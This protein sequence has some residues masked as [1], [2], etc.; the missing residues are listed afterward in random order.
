MAALAAEVVET[1]RLRLQ[2]GDVVVAHKVVSVAEGR[3]VPLAEVQPS[4]EAVRLAREVGKDPRL[5]GLV[6][7]E[8]WEV[9]RVLQR[10]FGVTDE[11]A[12]AATLPNPPGLPGGSVAPLCYHGADR[13]LVR[14]GGSWR[15]GVC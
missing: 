1:A 14:W 11:L 5:E 9:V 6:L 8:S 7:R 15:R 4:E 10:H 12:S 3:V 13:R 2:E